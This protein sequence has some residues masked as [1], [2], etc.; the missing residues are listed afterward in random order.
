MLKK[1]F[2][3]DYFSDLGVEFTNVKFSQKS[4]IS[5]EGNP[6]N[7]ILYQKPKTSPCPPPRYFKMRRFRAVFGPSKDP[8][9]NGVTVEFP[10]PNF[11]VFNLYLKSIIDAGALCVDLV[12]EEWSIIPP[13]LKGLNG[14]KSIS[15]TPS[16]DLIALPD[17]SKSVKITGRMSDY[18]SDSGVNGKPKF[19]IEYTPTD[20]AELA[21]G[22]I[23]QIADTEI[24]FPTN[25]NTPC[26]GPVEKSSICVIAD[27]SPRRIIAKGNSILQL[28][29]VSADNPPK[30]WSRMIPVQKRGDLLV[31][32]INKI[33]NY[34]GVQCLAYK[35]ESIK[36]IHL[37]VNLNALTGMPSGNQVNP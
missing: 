30:A 23:Q 24:Y 37:L 15:Y 19:A 14:N 4:G 18:H 13:F 34:K 8:A 21:L 36:N 9:L 27:Q 31:D 12:G 22:P 1:S 32:C 6:V 20:F 28:T 7:G 35:G 2:A 5:G 29:D 16:Y 3:I 25:T 11:F 33:G 17:T 26:L 10:I